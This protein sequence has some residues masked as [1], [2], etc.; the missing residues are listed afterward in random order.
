MQG[1]RYSIA[2]LLL[3]GLVTPFPF[4][5]AAPSLH[6]QKRSNSPRLLPH[7][8]ICLV[9]QVET[10]A[11]SEPLA[12]VQSERLARI[13]ILDALRGRS[14]NVEDQLDANNHRVVGPN[15]CGPNDLRLKIEANFDATRDEYSIVGQV[16]RSPLKIARLGVQA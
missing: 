14:R 5:A 11:S 6:A 3:A 10:N 16:S 4:A 12:S 9:V 15:D 7:Q 1:S 8:A 13:A 2:V